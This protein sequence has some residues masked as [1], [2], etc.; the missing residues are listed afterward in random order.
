MYTSGESW[1]KEKK[2]NR[3]TFHFLE[4]G[5]QR[6]I[7]AGEV[8][9][10]QNLYERYNQTLFLEGVFAASPHEAHA[11]TS[12]LTALILPWKRCLLMY[13]KRI[14]KIWDV[15]AL[16][17]FYLFI[18]CILRSPRTMQVQYIKHQYIRYISKRTKQKYVTETNKKALLHLKTYTK[19]KYVKETNRKKFPCEKRRVYK[20]HQTPL[21]KWQKE[22]Q[23]TNRKQDMSLHRSYYISKWFSSARSKTFADCD[24]TMFSGSEFQSVMVR[25]KNEFLKRLVRVW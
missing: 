19:Q 9:V 24:K 25:G 8:E 21:V 10:A 3:D 6:S 22:G 12:F 16:F 2:Q 4:P 5:D 7:L 14:S 17:Y 15:Q 11:H 20:I 1:P 18:Y 23:N 13:S